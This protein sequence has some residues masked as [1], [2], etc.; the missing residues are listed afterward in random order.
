VDNRF[1]TQITMTDDTEARLQGQVRDQVGVGAQ[2][3]AQIGEFKG[4]TR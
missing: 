3:W 4:V 2:V 1:V